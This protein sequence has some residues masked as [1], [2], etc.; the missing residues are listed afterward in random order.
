MRIR[1]IIKSNSK[2]MSISGAMA[3]AIKVGIISHP[4]RSAIVP[5][6]GARAEK[7]I[8]VNISKRRK[9]PNC[10]SFSITNGIELLI[11]TKN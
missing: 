5:G 11:R 4:L 9:T 2:T 10:F 8:A 3:G 6:S 7:I 1:H